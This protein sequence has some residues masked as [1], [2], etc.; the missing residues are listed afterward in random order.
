M[1]NFID[2]VNV[3]DLVVLR[4]DQ[5]PHTFYVLPN[6]PV[7]PVGEDG[8]PEFLFLIYTKDLSD[9]PDTDE[10]GGGYLQ[11]RTV[12]SLSDDQRAQ[13]TDALRQL[14]ATEQ[15]AGK[16]PFGNAITD[17][18]PILA[19]PLWTS[20]SV[21]LATFDV[22]AS[23]LVRQATGKAPVDL[24]GDL[25]ASFAATLSADGA[26]VFEGAFKAYQDGTHQL[27]LVLTYNLTYVGRVNARLTID[28][29]HSVVHQRVW[30]NAMPYRLITE[31]AVRYVPLTLNGPFT[32]ELLPQLREQ[33]G[34]VHAM[35]TRPAIVSAVQETISDSSVT[36]RIEEVSTGDPAAD[37][38]TRTSLLTLA[39][40]L[41]TDSLL[42]SL[43]TGGPQPG[44]TDPTATAPNTALLQLD[45]NATPGTATF[46]LELNDA[47]SLTRQASPNAPLHVMID[48]PATLAS[49]FHALRLAD[50]FFKD[51][52]VTFSTTGVDFSA[53][54]IAKIHVYYRYSQTD[55]A[56][57]GA[58][59]VERHDDAELTSADAVA[60]FRFD[61]AR[62]A[63]GGHK[64]QY[65]FMAEVYWQRGGAPTVVPWTKTD[66]RLVIITPPQLG[67]VKVE[68]VLTAPAGAVDSARVDIG[69]TASDG[70]AYTGAI[71]L[72]PA[73]PRATWLQSTG[74]IITPDDTAEPRQYDYTV[75][76]R[77]GPTVIVTPKRSSRQ[78][79]L[80]VSTPFVG[81]VTFS[82]MAQ[83]EWSGVSTIAG[84]LTYGDPSNSYSKVMPFALSATAPNLDL[85]VPVM[86]GGPRTASYT[87]RVAHPDGTHE[88]IA[89][90]L[91]EGLNFVGAAEAA[92]PL[93][94]TLRT[95]L[96]DFAADLKAVHVQLTFT[97]AGGQK[98]TAEHVF[99]SADSAPFTWTVPRQSADGSTY[100]TTVNFYGIDRTK[101]Q[102]L[103]LTGCTSTTVELDRTMSTTA[104]TNG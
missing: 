55:D 58:P 1:L 52:K 47:M 74:E 53:N 2:P 91:T 14:L 12:L 79:T 88:D 65:E 35:L 43:T 80:E 71:E 8:A 73:A 99:T 68:G 33:Y 41:L 22:A 67:A 37:A 64:E 59:L 103:Q 30:Q 4:E 69:Y 82:L 61:T 56:A 102:D 27:P 70:T 39:T 20:G 3:G 87:G 66:R 38:A 97:H 90:P 57:P 10:A 15:A 62:T 75:T 32:A 84:T 11:F 60:N 50:D 93:A 13:V 89:G 21:D 23:G 72:T 29:Q 34:I 85:T 6:D 28:A 44:T 19:T 86:T 78:D 36:V 94:V 95:E 101:D 24:T 96:L 81:S 77:V 9:V 17:T 63:S 100:D 40:N 16:K 98:T 83:A 46:H 45:D 49:C 25:G 104:T 26:G 7:V 92:A 76:Y 18:E 48:D 54:G 5:N 51:M 31:G 42:P